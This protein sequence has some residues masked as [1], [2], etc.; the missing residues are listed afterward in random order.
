MHCNKKAACKAVS[1]S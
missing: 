1:I